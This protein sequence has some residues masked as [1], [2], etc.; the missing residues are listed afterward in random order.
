MVTRSICSRCSSMLCKCLYIY[1]ISQFPALKQAGVCNSWSKPFAP[2]H[3]A[4]THT[5]RTQTHT[6]THRTHAWSKCSSNMMSYWVTCTADGNVL[7]LK[8]H[9]N[10]C[11]L[12]SVRG[13]GQCLYGGPG[14]KLASNDS[15]SKRISKP[16]ISDQRIW[17]RLWQ[18]PC[19]FITKFQGRFGRRLNGFRK[20]PGNYIHTYIYI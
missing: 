9:A 8:S 19:S 15:V 16:Q 10:N 3:C 4:Q 18:L 14:R 1:I 6:H 2:K 13:A 12:T 7:Q 11:G 17:N 5:H 20:I